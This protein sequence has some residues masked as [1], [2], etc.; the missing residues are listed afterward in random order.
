MGRSCCQAE[1]K[2]RPSVKTWFQARM[3]TDLRRLVGQNGSPT[4]NAST[5]QASRRHRPPGDHLRRHHRS[6]STARRLEHFRNVSLR[7]RGVRA[8]AGGGH[9]ALPWGCPRIA[10]QISWVA[11]LLAQLWVILPVRMLL[12]HLR[13][14]GSFD[15][16]TVLACLCGS[17]TESREARWHVEQGAGRRKRE[18][19]RG[20][21]WLAGRPRRSGVG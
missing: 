19:R 7:T 10:Q 17:A 2:R 1:T 9:P 4:T 3:R 18:S 21:R 14:A 20:R 8:C 6:S 15:E 16:L 12:S 5:S 13:S 11:P